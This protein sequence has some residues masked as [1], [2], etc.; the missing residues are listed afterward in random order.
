[1]TSAM[2][3]EQLNAADR[4]AFVAAIGFTFEG[5]SWIAEEAWP[6]RPFESRDALLATMLEIVASAPEERHV[7]LIRAHPDLAGRVAREGRLSPPSANEQ[8]AAGL[9]RLTPQEIAR[10]DELNAGYR[11]RFGFP[12]VICAREQTTAS[13]LGALERRI[14]NDRAAEIAVALREIA[15]IAR[16]RLKD[17][18]P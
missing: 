9:D 14:A 13:I 1:M 4:A 11:A 6:Q 16:L 17:A 3:I 15:S 10:F 18:M 8:A 7:A 12:F 5:S 2:T